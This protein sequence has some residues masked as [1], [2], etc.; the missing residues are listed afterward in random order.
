MKHLK[1][2]VLLA[3]LRMFVKSIFIYIRRQIM[4]SI[5]YLF[6]NKQLDFPTARQN[7]HTDCGSTSVQTMLAYYGIDER[8]DDLDK[9][10]KLDKDGVSYTNMIKLFHKYN[11]KTDFGPMNQIILKNYLDESIP[12]IILI[13]AYKDNNT[14]THTRDNYE[15]G[16]Y[17]T[18]TGYDDTKFIIE[19]PSLNNKLGYISFDELDIR[20]HG[21]GENKKDKLEFFGI[22]VSGKPKFESNQ[23]IK[24]E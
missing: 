3:K 2:G 11:L 19:D 18:V 20:W 21:V 13:Q 22:A 14:K 5:S 6:E 16:H 15:N 17:V 12:V 1:N 9:K 23:I 24:V 4:I 8:Q 7:N 10:L